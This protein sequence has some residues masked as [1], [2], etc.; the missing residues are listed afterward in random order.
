MNFFTENLKVFKKIFIPLFALVVLSSNIDQY[1]NMQ[2]EMALRNPDG[3]QGLVYWYGFFSLLSSVVF[4]VILMSFALFAFKPLHDFSNTLGAFIQ[5]YLNQM[6]IETLRTWGKTLL[7][8]LFLILPGIWKYLELSL[9]PL[10]VTFSKNYDEGHVDALKLSSQ[11]FRRRWVKITALFLVF[12]VMT[13]L[14]LSV[15]FDAYRLIWKTPLSSLILSA[16]DTYL[17]LISTHLLFI[18]FKNE[19]NQNDPSHV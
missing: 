18:I 4:P 2:M 17:L 16:L 7:W 19:V 15:F 1:L 10:V 12:H 8:S 3:A 13:P 9:V 14:L 5:K 6:F 11:I